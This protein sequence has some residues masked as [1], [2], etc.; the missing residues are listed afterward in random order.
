MPDEAGSRLGHDD[1][2]ATIGSTVLCGLLIASC[3]AAPLGA[4]QDRDLEA[5]RLAA[6]QGDAQ[7]Q[8]RLGAVY[9]DGV[10]AE[11]DHAE[12][13]R[14]SRLAADQGHLGARSH[15]AYLSEVGFGIGETTAALSALADKSVNVAVIPIAAALGYAAAPSAAFSP[16][17]S[18]IA[19]SSL[20]GKTWV[21]PAD[22]SAAPVR[23]WGNNS[24]RAAFSPDGSHIVT[25]GTDGVARVFRTSAES[26]PVLLV[27]TYPEGGTS[28]GQR[29]QVWEAAFSPDGSRIVTVADDHV[30]EWRADGVGQPVVLTLAAPSVPSRAAAFSQDGTRIVTTYYDRTIRVWGVDGTSQSVIQTGYDFP[31]SSAAFS[32]DGTRVLTTE[33][34]STTAEVW[35]V[36]GE[37]DPIV[38][39][40]HADRVNSAVFSPDGARI[41]TAS[42]DGTARVWPADGTGEP[43]VLSGHDGGVRAAFSPDSARIVTASS[44]TARVWR[45]DGGGKPVVLNI[46]ADSLN[47]VQF[48]PHGRRVVMASRDRTA[49]VWR[50]TQAPAD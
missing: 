3:L 44:A 24:G 40:G 11:R 31:I 30:R 7:A 13:L 9:L 15:L 42:D 35:W 8:Y 10:G 6:E 16:D 33:N 17:G 18:R 1:V 37:G 22:G 43:V 29:A 49:W 21:W 26:E 41:V 47:G 20:T 14:W 12:A 32:P 36:D 23:L 4:G 27:H 39:A 34:R 5:L 28:E 46:R 38:L 48:G 45:A 2:T 25:A 19:T 50:W